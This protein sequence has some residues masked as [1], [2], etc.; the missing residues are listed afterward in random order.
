[1][2]EKVEK[3]LEDALYD[4]EQMKVTSDDEGAEWAERFEKDFYHFID[5]LKEWM[6]SW[7]EKPK[8]VEDAEQTAEIR[9]WNN[10]LPDPLKLNFLSELE[11]II[12]GIETERFD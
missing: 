1:M 7:P 12:D 3:A 11:D 9:A 5:M 8:S 4:W 10:R 6:S 2:V